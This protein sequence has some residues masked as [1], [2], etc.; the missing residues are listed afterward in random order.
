[1]KFLY[2]VGISFFI[3][4]FSLLSKP[5]KPM[6]RMKKIFETKVMSNHKNKFSQIKNLFKY[7][8]PMYKS[9]NERKRKKTM[10]YPNDWKT[11]FQNK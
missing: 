9:E 3:F 4:S 8:E 2:F 7:E 6:T 11:F 5:K 1:M 10:R